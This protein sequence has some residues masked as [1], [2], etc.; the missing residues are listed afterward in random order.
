M[1]CT[2]AL[3]DLER[4]YDR[5]LELTRDQEACLRSGNVTALAEILGRKNDA[6]S[7]A[8]E[9]TSKV[10]DGDA[11]RGTPGFQEALNRIGCILAKTVSAEDRCQ[12]LVPPQKQSSGHRQ[13]V[14]AY[15]GLSAKR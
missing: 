2:S 15:T 5:V 13:A 12:A 14:A 6:L 1:D 9:L 3:V 4:L 10:M 11:A 7:R 8:Q